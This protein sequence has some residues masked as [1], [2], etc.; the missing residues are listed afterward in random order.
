MTATT[1]PTS[2][3][4]S[5]DPLSPG[6]KQDPDRYWRELRTQDPVHH[7]TLPED[8][9]GLMS[10]N[11]LAAEPTSEFWSALSYD[12][13]RHILMNPKTYSST[14]GPGPERMAQLIEVLLFADDP[15][16]IRQR[17]LAA[18][19][20]TPSAVDR[21]LPQIQRT[22]DDLIDLFADAGAMEI[23]RDLAL[24]LSIRT[25]AG[26]VGIPIERVDDFRRWGNAIVATFGGDPSALEGGF[27]AIG[28]LFGYTQT[29]VDAIRAGNADSID[30]GLSDG[31]LAALVH[32]EFDGT[33]LN[34]DELHWI[35]LQLI[36]AGFETTSTATANGV[37]LLCTHPDQR[38]LYDTADE[39]GKKSAVEEIIRYA[40][41]LEGLFRTS[42]EDVELSG[43]PIP[44]GAKIR[45]VFA[46]ANRDEKQFRDAGAF[47]IDRDPAELRKHLGFG[48]GPHACI[49]AALA[50]AELRIVFETLFRRLPGLDL[51][52]E[53]LAVRSTV[54][55]I[56]GFNELHIRWDPARVRP[57]SNAAI[58]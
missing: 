26:I 41:P 35:V 58:A 18:K 2:P 29:L 1:G 31:V 53:K 11:P 54:L 9:A 30:P 33:H 57:A 19:A 47:R 5:Y 15:V 24:P 23:M 22:A 28:E 7:Y 34:D 55:T 25:I 20:F 37:Y 14:Q 51:D 49:G 56:N 4:Q 39:A 52:P 17:R 38:A 10:Q 43:C 42:N 44:K 6:V 48:L 40:S 32:A 27:V 45:P 21:L 36:T 46:S 3:A 12:D 16:H 8:L 50:R 13:V